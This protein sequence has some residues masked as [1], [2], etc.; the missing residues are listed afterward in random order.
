MT[1][2]SLVTG[3]GIVAAQTVLLYLIS[4]RLLLGLVLGTLASHA[5][6]WLG[7]ALINILRLPGNLLHEL[8]HAAGYIVSGY[9]IRDLGTCLSDS[10][11][12]GYCEPG[13]PWSPVHWMP[14]AAAI[15]AAAPLFVGALALRVVAY[16]LEV[17]LPAADVASEGLASAAE[18][19]IADI[20]HF[21]TDMDWGSWQTYVFWYFALS[22]G[23]ELAPSDVDIRKGGL[24]IALLA[25]VLV[26]TIYA[27]PHASIHPELGEAFYKALR[28]VLSSLSTAL[29]AGLIGCGL[30]GAVTGIIAATVGRP[31]RR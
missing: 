22:I 12:R 10:E 27:V 20:R 11:G 5:R 2:H 25:G 8:S 31:R 16:S 1:S 24:V 7:R 17:D 15:A 26:L 3:L 19:I 30:V 9:T 14:L 4:R 13:K 29:F 6:G 18:H 23:T 21:L 28:Y